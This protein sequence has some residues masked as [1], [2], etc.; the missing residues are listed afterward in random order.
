MRIRAPL[1]LLLA[2]CTVLTWALAPHGTRV[3]ASQIS[4]AIFT[5]NVNDTQVNGNIYMDKTQVYL[6]GGPGKNA[7]V[8]AAGLPAGVYVFQV[9]DPSGKSLL[10]TDAAGCR[11]F[12]VNAAGYMTDVNPS[13]AFGCAHSTGV[14]SVTGGITVQLM[15]YNDTPNN[16]G[17]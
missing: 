14:D 15:P 9:T 5:T 6:N 10:S 13:L 2:L 4:G 11:Q 17:E 8:G 3:Y 1:C 7:P 16:G 12:T